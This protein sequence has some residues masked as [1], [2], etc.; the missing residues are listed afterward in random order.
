[1]KI[2]M[3][4]SFYPPY[5]VGGADT[6][7]KYFAE[8]LVK[9]GHEVHVLFSMD[10]FKFKRPYV[11]KKEE[12]N[13]VHVHALNSPLGNLEPVLN[14]SVS[15]MPSTFDGFKKLVKENH[16][17][18][19]HHHNISLLG[20]RVLKKLAPYKSF[21]TAHDFWLVCPKYD[22]Y[23]F[24]K[25]CEKRTCFTCL[26]IH[27][28]PYPLYQ[29]TPDFRATVNKD[30]DHIIA[31]SQYMRGRILRE[32]DKPVT[33]NWNFVAE[34]PKVLE[35]PQEKN[36]FLFVGQLERHKGILPLIEAFK[37]LDQT[38]LIF[39]K[40]SLEAQVCASIEGHHNIIYKGWASTPNQVVSYMKH[41]QAL[42]LPSLWA[43]NNPIVMLEA[44][45]I[46]TP[47]IGSRN[48]GIPEIVELL[49][50]RLLFDS[51]SFDGLVEI[52]G[53][54]KRNKYSVSRIRDIYKKNFSWA[55]HKDRL[56]RVGYFG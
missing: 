30:V 29:L 22:L 32:F 37:K 51:S 24:G 55:A 45:S 13:G 26:P 11:K 42:I 15:T 23:K 53:S 50:K 49:D 31:P 25:I 39:G 56:T 41:A 16:F 54:F 2:L 44:L 35:T 43:E 12:Y 48:G 20:H 5:H 3:T 28:K 21:Y 7:V 10:A 19:V 38:L 4:T 17:D 46:G 1:M 47:V 6:L 8:A 34:P 33:V 14:Y 40:G 52:V 18:L 27:K 9:E 36:Y